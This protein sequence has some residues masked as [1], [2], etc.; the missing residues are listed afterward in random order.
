MVS[1]V[2]SEHGGSRET[3]RS[4]QETEAKDRES[5]DNLDYVV[6]SRL[7]FNYEFSN[8]VGEKPNCRPS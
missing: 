3:S 2:L 7:N 8:S 4:T 1:E 5:E 6:R